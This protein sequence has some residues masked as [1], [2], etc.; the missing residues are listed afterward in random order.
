[1][2]TRVRAGTLGG[3]ALLALAGLSLTLSS[4]GSPSAAS[5]PPSCGAGSP[6]LTVVGTGLATGTPDLLTISVDVSVTGASAAG[7][8]ADDNA[9]TAAVLAAFTQGGVAAK[10]VQ[11]TGLS[12]Q[13]D[14][15]FTGGRQVLT[16]Y[17]V[18][19]TVVAKL[20]DLP[21]AGAT[22]DAVAVAAG[23][24]AR[25]N[26]LDFSL[27]DPR[28]L[29]DRARR[30]AV[31]QAVDHARSMALAAG[32]RL[33]PVCTLTDDSAAANQLLPQSS[34]GGLRAGTA[35]PVPAVPV[36]AGTEQVSASV[37]LVYALVS[38]RA[39]TPATGSA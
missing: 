22:I 38:G 32:D 29:Q 6:K 8:L 39:G 16:G 2:R 3:A 9:R 25:I 18:D 26:S 19:N 5:D 17:G 35:S 36:T 20:R 33:G 27:N 30:D 11:T 7:T 37:T 13:P 24:A 1:M 21:R 4:C 15:A 14:F 34:L 28:G 10:D 12:V 23:D 31:H